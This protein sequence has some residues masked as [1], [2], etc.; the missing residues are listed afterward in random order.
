MELTQSAFNILLDMTSLRDEIAAQS[1][2]Q[3]DKEHTHDSSECQSEERVHSQP[4][5]RSDLS[6][7]H[8]YYYDGQQ[9]VSLS[10]DDLLKRIAAHPRS[11]HFIWVPQQSS[12]RS[13]K[14]IPNLVKAVH[15][16]LTQSGRYQEP[17]KVSDDQQ[18]KRVN[19]H[20]A[21]H[22]ADHE[23]SHQLTEECSSTK[24]DD[25]DWPSGINVNQSEPSR[26]VQATYLSVPETAFTRFTLQLSDPEQI[27]PYIGWDSTLKSGG[28]FINTPRVL[29]VGDYV[30]LTLMVG[31]Q[32]LI[33]FETPISWVRLPR[34]AQDHFGGGVGISWS[35]VITEDQIRVIAQAT[36]GIEY[37]FYAA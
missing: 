15:Y 26:Q 32:T 20:N 25:Y 7:K 9:R 17:V 37:E 24:L 12:W 11:Q 21:D 2:A 27:R 3:N 33:T 18:V 31:E 28:L 1:K 30:Q 36:Q 8:I 5:L 14:T 23:M 35:E 16:H 13:W 29:N 4:D 19:D 22:S 6:P 10:R 34:N